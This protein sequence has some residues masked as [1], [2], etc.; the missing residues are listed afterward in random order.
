MSTSVKPIDPISDFSFSIFRLNGFLLRNGDRI[1]KSIG[2]SSARW[3]VLGRL[4]HQPQ[5]VAAIARSMGHA[6]QSVQRI[7]DILVNEGLATYEPNP[8]DKRAKLMALTPQGENMLKA[9]Y[10]QYGEWQNHIINKLNTDKLAAIANALDKI[11]DI[12]EADEH[13]TNK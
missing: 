8:Q 4:G 2:Q 5:T 10:A 11:A 7:A 3:Q 13:Q 1:T 12:L 9:I 6:R